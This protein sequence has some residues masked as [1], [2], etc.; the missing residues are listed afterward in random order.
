MKSGVLLSYMSLLALGIA[1]NF[2]L[3]PI[4]VNLLLTTFF[5]IYIGA[6]HSLHSV[7]EEATMTSED[8]YWFP[9]TGSCVLFGLYMA[10]K[11]F[12]KE[13]VNSLLTAYFFVVG[14][15]A[16]A[17]SISP[18]IE[19]IMYGNK[20]G[21]YVIDWEFKLPFV[22]EPIKIQ[23]TWALILSLIL[24][25][26]FGYWYLETKHWCG[27]NIFGIAFSIQGISQL[28]LGSYKVGAILLTGLFFYD[29]FWVF[30]TDVMVTVAKS[31]DAPIKLIFPRALATAD[32]DAVFSILGLGDIVIPGIFIALLLRFDAKRAIDAGAKAMEKA[33]G[34]KSALVP[35]SFTKT[36]FNITMIAYTIG[37]ATTVLIMYHFKAA[38]P[39]LLYLVPACLISSFG[40]AVVR[41][42]VSVLLAYTEETAEEDTK[43]TKKEN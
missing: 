1:G 22:D 23:L 27:N 6:H 33:P 8:A 10:F 31:F 18:L 17:G 5:V 26:I 15:V 12:K 11:M 20:E 30:G 21:K 29:I 25:S 9:L 2:V 32:T 39:A 28:S 41:G 16:L 34:D 43:D 40:M 37:L 3:I 38:Q 7:D 24:S 42:E 14:V 4:N 35:E 36:Y 19:S 13:Y